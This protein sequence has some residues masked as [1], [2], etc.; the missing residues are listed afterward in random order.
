MANNRE[1]ICLQDFAI[2]QK[3]FAFKSK[4]Y[5]DDGVA[6]V[7]VS[8]LTSDSI[9]ISDLRYVSDEVASDKSNF[10]LLHNDVV[11]ATVGSWPKNPAS[12]V[13]KVIKVPRKCDNYLLNQN[14]VR[15]RVKT[16]ENSDQLFLYY[17]LKSKAFSDYIISTAQGSANQASIT[18]KDIYAFEFYCPSQFERKRIA[19]IL[20]TLDDKSEVNLQT[21]Q[22]LER[23]AQALFKSWFIDFDPVVDNALALGAKISDFPE[24]LQAKAK[25]RECV[26]NSEEYQPVV[27]N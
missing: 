10:K 4:D 16:N 22:T 27:V 7:R 1:L 19:Q 25:L 8:N 13:G 14:A 20:S 5:I 15:F 11:I 17:L 3:G 23:M 21:N 26:R 24:T 18:L 9:D 6:V 12:V 2:H